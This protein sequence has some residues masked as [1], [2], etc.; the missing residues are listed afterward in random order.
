MTGQDVRT[1]QEGWGITQPICVMPGTQSIVGSTYAKSLPITGTFVIRGV[2]I[3]TDK[4][5]GSSYVRF[6]YT[7]APFVVQA[8]LFN[9]TSIV[10]TYSTIVNS[11]IPY[12]ALPLAFGAIDIDGLN[13]PV[14]QPGASLWAS[15]ELAGPSGATNL[16]VT[17]LIELTS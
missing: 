17:F 10:S 14:L 4:P 6:G 15:L 7:S 11:N 9:A 8:D 13:I 2:R 3:Q 12:P 5:A 16:G 1:A